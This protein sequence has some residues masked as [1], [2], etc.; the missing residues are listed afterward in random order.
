MTSGRA[1]NFLSGLMDSFE[2]MD[3]TSGWVSRDPEVVACIHR[4]VKCRRLGICY[5]TAAVQDWFLG[6]Y[7]IPRRT[8]F[9]IAEDDAARRG[10]NLPSHLFTVHKAGRGTWRWLEGSWEPYRGNDYSA[11]T[12]N[13]MARTVR[14]LMEYREGRYYRLVPIGE[15]PCAG[16]SLPQYYGELVKNLWK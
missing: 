7:R 16:L 3:D 12:S 10:G 13:D 11:A 2:Y 4:G 1:L 8:F 6:E 15:L 9:L 14:D 5:D